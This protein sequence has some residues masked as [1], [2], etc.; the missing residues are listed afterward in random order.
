MASVSPTNP[1]A[2]NNVLASPR[3]KRVYKRN[4]RP[5]VKELKKNAA[6]A[7]RKIIAPKEPPK[8]IHISLRQLK[9][10]PYVWKLNAEEIKRL[11]G[12]RGEEVNDVINRTLNR[13]RRRD[14]PCHWTRKNIRVLIQLIKEGILYPTIIQTRKAALAKCSSLSAI[15]EESI[16]ALGEMND[17]LSPQGT[18]WDAE[19]DDSVGEDYAESD[20]DSNYTDDDLDSE[21]TIAS[22]TLEDCDN[23]RRITRCKYAENPISQCIS[24]LKTRV[25]S[26]ELVGED[27]TESN[28]NTS[29]QKLPSPLSVLTCG[30]VISHSRITPPGSENICE[31][32]R[33]QPNTNS[34][35]IAIEKFK[36]LLE[37]ERRE[38]ATIAAR[39]QEYEKEVSKLRGK[40]MVVKDQRDSLKSDLETATSKINE[41]LDWFS[42]PNGNPAIWYVI[43]PE[44]RQR[45]T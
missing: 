5:E 29:I 27:S 12:E 45:Y 6:E 13:P 21:P 43:E 35:S 9:R 19:T 23:N 33:T 37:E 41:Y 36:N 39:L 44:L 40:I 38:K 31:E 26:P 15:E 18:I 11:P 2:P 25:P 42:G 3:A 34:V 17:T 16:D 10:V 14:S 22:G 24:P 30:P 28:D 8:S 20:A 1:T 7:I 4:K 32:G